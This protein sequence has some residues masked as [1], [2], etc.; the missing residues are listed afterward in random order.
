MNEQIERF[1]GIA[2]RCQQCN[3]P[4]RP[5]YESQKQDLDEPR[6][7][8]RRVYIEDFHLLE[9]LGLTSG[10]EVVDPGIDESDAAYFAN[11]W[12]GGWCNKN[13][14]YYQ[15]KSVRKVKSR[16]FLGTFGARGDGFFCKT[17]C[18]YAWSVRH[19]KA[20]QR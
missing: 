14:K 5:N 13:K 4:L 8:F 16:K 10:G 15:L 11:G 20:H 6:T 18:G 3:K 17:E 9:N 2:P 1:R 12:R 7:E 19:L